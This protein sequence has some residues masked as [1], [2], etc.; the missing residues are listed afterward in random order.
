MAKQQP[1]PSHWTLV[2]RKQEKRERSYLFWFQER[3]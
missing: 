2:K 1:S 3:E